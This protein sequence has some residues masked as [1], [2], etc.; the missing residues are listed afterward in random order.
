MEQNI[1]RLVLTDEALNFLRSLPKPARD[2]INYNIH[3]VVNRYGTNEPNT[4]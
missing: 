4:I 1:F 3:R 2:K